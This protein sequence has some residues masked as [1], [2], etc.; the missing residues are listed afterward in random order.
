M[1]HLVS[2][3]RNRLVYPANTTL[4][5]VE[6]PT[7]PAVPGYLSPVTDSTWG[8]R[9]TR[10]SDVNNRRNVYSRTPGWNKDQSRIVLGYYNAS[11]GAILNGV[12]YEQ[13]LVWNMPS[14][15]HWSSVYPD[16][17]YSANNSSANLY[18]YTAA[19]VRT[20]VHD[21]SATYSLVSLGDGEG[22]VSNDDHALV[23]MTQTAGGAQGILVYDPIADSIR[24]TRSFSS[25]PN[26]A[27]ISQSGT[28]VGV[29]WATNGSG[30]EQGVWVHDAATLTPQRQITTYGSRHCDPGID[31]AGNE[32]IVYELSGVK[33]S[34]FADG[35]TTTLVTSPSAYGYQ[36][37]SCRN[38]DR[39]GWA[40]LSSYKYDSNDYKGRDQIVAVKLDGSE[41]VE[42][43]CFAN[44]RTNTGA[45]PVAVPSRDGTRVLFGSE[46]GVPGTTY[47]YIAEKV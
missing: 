29:V 18:A 17:L 4:T 16:R 23:L 15:A 27:W 7:I 44:Q 8:T 5:L 33:M 41:T 34:R 46:W 38:L 3:T 47:A 36:H 22:S 14:D 26:N 35:T 10:V 42:V 24:S 31:S 1:G 6:P 37:I 21:F 28:Y 45:A 40:Y 11:Y 13:L 43:F 25:R 32:V 9:V 20:T 39:P 30:A 19:G 2:A 12:T